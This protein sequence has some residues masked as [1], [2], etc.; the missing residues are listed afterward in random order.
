MDDVL[1]ARVLEALA[2]ADSAALA[3]TDQLAGLWRDFYAARGLDLA[4]PQIADS[5]LRAMTMVY[6]LLMAGHSAGELDDAAWGVVT[7]VLASGAAAVT[8]T[9][10]VESPGQ[11][12]LL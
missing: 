12:R 10:S 11:G 1:G 2:D 5:A 7:E 4:E 3:R 6:G 8:I 9:R